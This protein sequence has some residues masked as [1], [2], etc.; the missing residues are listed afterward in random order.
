MGS[1]T[2][3]TTNQPVD[4]TSDQSIE[5]KTVYGVL[6]ESGGDPNEFLNR[7]GGYST[8]FGS[9]NVSGTGT[10]IVG[11]LP[12]L[13]NTFTTAIIDSGV[14]ISSLVQPSATEIVNDASDLPAPSGGVITLE[15]KAYLFKGDVDLGTD[16]LL[17][18][19]NTVIN[20]IAGRP[21]TNSANAL[22]SFDGVS[23]ASLIG[24]QGLSNSGGPAL[25]SINGASPIV[26]DANLTGTIGMVVDGSSLDAEGVRMNAGTSLLTTANACPNVR[27]NNFSGSNFTGSVMSIDGT[28]SRLDLVDIVVPTGLQGLV[29]EATGTVNNL[30]TENVNFATTTEALV[31]SGSVGTWTAGSGEFFSLTEIAF[32][33]DGNI[34]QGMQLNGTRAFSLSKEAVSIVGSSIDGMIWSGGAIF[35]NNGSSSALV[36][37]TNSA[38]INQSARFTNVAFITNGGTSLSGID[39]QDLNYDFTSCFNVEDSYYLG[40]A[41]V[42][43]TGTTNNPGVGQW[44]DVVATFSECDEISR[45][46]VDSAGVFTFN[47]LEDIPVSWAGAVHV[48]RSGGVGP[49]LFELR[50]VKSLDGGSSYN[51]FNVDA[52]VPIDLDNRVKSAPFTLEDIATTDDG[53]NQQVKYKLQCR[54][55]ENNTIDL[56]TE[57]GQLQIRRSL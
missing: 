14:P 13:N 11:N 2:N 17:A 8:P 24:I 49:I 3:A 50:W 26:R 39:P 5:N 42:T 53:V 12:V 41:D 35:T 30:T 56:F 55:T 19:E 51:E 36:G 46:S 32:L 57:G 18:V 4:T 7:A 23:S 31:L 54:N 28:V 48:R 20:T 21:I 27:V 15:D 22:L 44:T 16:T 38:N 29:I 45:W 10:S 6:L 47:G 33:L 1:N 37:D 52:R 9:G 43:S 25:E 34:T 40:C